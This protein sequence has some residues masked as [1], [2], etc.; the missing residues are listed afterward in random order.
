MPAPLNRFKAKLTT[1]ETQLGLWL[2]MGTG[3]SAEIAA[4]A[5][6]D[7]LVIDGEH[8]P[9]DVTSIH[10]QLMALSGH[11]VSPVV[12]I[13]H[14]DPALIKQMLDLGA[15]T[16]LCPMVNS[17]EEAKAIVRAMR[18][19]PHGIRGVGHMLGRPSAFNGITDYLETAADQLCLIVQ[20]ESVA[21]M[22]ALEEIC[23]VDGV[24]GVF[25][26]PADLS[27]DMGLLPDITHPEVRASVTDGLSRIRAVGKGAGIIDG[28]P[29]LIQQD[30]DAGAN[31][32]AVGIDV[33][34]LANTLRGLVRQW[35]PA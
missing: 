28:D 9:N 27:A 29:T 17:A 25:I 22:D 10:Q 2:S 16:L 1:G 34:L 8:S 20:A 4:S 11:D 12:R 5:G 3:Y 31:F 13:P 18:Y 15:Q 35:K 6:F 26:G 19:P 33:V 14:N 32:V 30:I 21:A 24:D 7:W 23:A